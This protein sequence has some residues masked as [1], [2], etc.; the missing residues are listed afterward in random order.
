MGSEYSVIILIMLAGVVC[1]AGCTTPPPVPEAT[2][3]PQPVSIPATIPPPPTQTQTVTIAPAVATMTTVVP[4]TPAVPADPADVSKIQFI[5]YSDNDFS[6]EYP[7]TWKVSKST[8]TINP[9]IQGGTVQN[10]NASRCYQSEITTIG[11]FDFNQ[12]EEMK[13]SARI[14]TFTSADGKEKAVAFISD[15][16]DNLAGNYVISPTCDWAKDLVTADYPDIGGAEVSDCR[17]AQSG[18][19]MYSQYTLTAPQG[20]AE[21]PLAYTMKNYVTVH[22]L[23]EF[24][25]IS[26]NGNIQKYHDLKEYMFSSITPGDVP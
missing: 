5:K 1:M 8:Y 3:T 7:S 6:L 10:P 11:P 15:F 26:D 12:Y 16:R 18:N 19:A 2:P 21:Y 25:F 14:V 13:Q 4:A 22:H 17:F 23:Y 20:S 9:C 24:A